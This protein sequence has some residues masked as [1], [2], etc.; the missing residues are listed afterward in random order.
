MATELAFSREVAFACAPFAKQSLWLT[1]KNKIYCNRCK[2]ALV[3]G[4]RV[5]VLSSVGPL[6][7]PTVIPIIPWLTSAT[8]HELLIDFNRR[9]SPDPTNHS[10][11]LC[12]AKKLIQ[13]AVAITST[14]SGGDFSG[15]NMRIRRK[16]I[17]SE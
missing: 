8:H 9:K 12:R 14:P 7:Q 11:P 16:N 3:A 4:S 13:V 5:E 15:V 10:P 6:F 2:D 17:L 1:N